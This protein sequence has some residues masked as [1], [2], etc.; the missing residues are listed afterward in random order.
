MAG[1][2]KRL[3]FSGGSLSQLFC[4]SFQQNGVAAMGVLPCRN[5]YDPVHYPLAALIN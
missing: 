3:V 2:G 4:G 1:M 5:I